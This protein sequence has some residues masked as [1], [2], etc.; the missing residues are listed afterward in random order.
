[1][2]RR[3][4]AQPSE[5]SADGNKV[6]SWT[7]NPMTTLVDSPDMSIRR[8]L[9]RTYE[10]IR[11]DQLKSEG[12]SSD[13][14]RTKT[15]TTV[16]PSGF[17]VDETTG[18]PLPTRVKQIQ[19]ANRAKKLQQLISEKEKIDAGIIAKKQRALEAEKELGSSR[20]ANIPSTET[21]APDPSDQ[22]QS[23]ALVV[24]GQSPTR[25]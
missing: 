2:E 16:S 17:V 11:E 20:L 15:K 12:L 22:I 23:L 9:D 14:E 18:E 1:M 10:E 8:E 25:Q 5:T 21:T 3:G 4:V 19:P 24:C 13:I 7:V 6:T